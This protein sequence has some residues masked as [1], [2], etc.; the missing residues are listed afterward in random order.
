MCSFDEEGL[1]FYNPET[2]CKS[3]MAP[4]CLN[5]IDYFFVGEK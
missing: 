4:D 2:L 1:L 3:R 5:E